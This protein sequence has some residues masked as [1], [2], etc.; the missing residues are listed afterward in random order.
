MVDVALVVKKALKKPELELFNIDFKSYLLEMAGHILNNMKKQRLF[1]SLI[2]MN[3]GIWLEEIVEGCRR[4][5][6]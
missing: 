6:M 1:P 3:V 5:I 2:L 4:R